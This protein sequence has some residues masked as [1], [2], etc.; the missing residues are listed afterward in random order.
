M[1]VHIDHVAKEEVL[2][3]FVLPECLHVPVAAINEDAIRLY[4]GTI[5]RILAYGS[6]NRAL[7]VKVKSPPF[8]DPTL[9]IAKLQSAA[10]LHSPMQVWVHISYNGYRRAYKKAFPNENIEEKVISHAM[11]RRIAGL[12][13]FQYVRISPVTRGS[14]SS[15]SFSEQWGVDL[16][17]T[18]RQMEANR[19][20][21][22]FIHYGDL[23]AIMLMM[24]IKLG[25]G[26]MDTVNEGQKLIRPSR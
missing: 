6:P 17:S 14:N 24:D 18:P 22:A 4:I 11:N 20:R 15:S 1:V 19:N 26:V 12:Q 8:L 3:Q 13:G 5:E 10:I 9:P 16:H 2:R 25:G 7:F 21:G 23:A